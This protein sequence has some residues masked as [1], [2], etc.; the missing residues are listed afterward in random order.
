MIAPL[1]LP[2]LCH[3]VSSR[4][5]YSC[6]SVSLGYSLLLLWRMFSPVPCVSIVSCLSSF[7]SSLF[8]PVVSCVHLCPPPPRS[9]ACLCDITCFGC[10][11]LV[12]LPVLILVQSL[13]RSSALT[14]FFFRF[15]VFCIALFKSEFQRAFGL[16][17]PLYTKHHLQVRLVSWVLNRCK[18][19]TSIGKNR[20]D[21]WPSQTY[22]QLFLSYIILAYFGSV[23]IDLLYEEAGSRQ[24][25]S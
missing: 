11:A 17:T 5:Q 19:I 13:S 7:E 1:V 2:G 15:W 16:W 12:K 3:L 18:N 9:S 6:L 14:P 4:C 24:E 22:N 20:C 23:L 10:L 8:S 21:W 25:R